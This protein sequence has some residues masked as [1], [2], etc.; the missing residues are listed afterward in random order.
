MTRAAHPPADA[1][2]VE[3]W[4]AVAREWTAAVRA[5]LDPVRAIAGESLVKVVRQVP[6]GPILDAG[7]GEGWLARELARLGHRVT[8]FDGAAGMVAQARD[9]PAKAGVDFR[10]LTFAEASSGPRKMGSAYGTIVFNFSLLEE[11]I[12][13]ILT[14]ASSLLFPYGRLLVQAEHPFAAVG[15]YR[16]GWRVLRE[17]APGAA[18]SRP[19]PWFFRT[20]STW[21]V[22]LRRAG[23]LLVETYEPLDP[24]T[25]APVSLILSA[26]IPERRAK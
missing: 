13:P 19:I 6:T 8:A 21:V 20:F 4:S 14:A 7:C 16:D 1:R 3:G 22:E 12:T 26:T 5:G 25:G 9:A 15:D 23:L 18:L 24:R 11:R 10:V 2:T 17:A